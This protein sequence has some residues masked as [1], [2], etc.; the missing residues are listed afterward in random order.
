MRDMYWLQ[1]PGMRKISVRT[2]QQYVSDRRV[3]VWFAFVHSY[4][5]GSSLATRRQSS[6]RRRGRPLAPLSLSPV[7]RDARSSNARGDSSPRCTWSSLRSA[8]A[9]CDIVRSAEACR[10][11]ILSG[12]RS[13]G[14][15]EGR[16]RE[17]HYRGCSIRRRSDHVRASRQRRM[18]SPAPGS[19]RTF[20]VFVSSTF[21]DFIEER[22]ALQRYVFP[23]LAELSRVAR[24][25]SRQSTCAGASAKKPAWTSA[26]SPSAST[27]SPAASG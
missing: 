25:G 16:G 12:R 24:A 10:L 1:A 2:I 22:N 17:Q 3:R 11:P 27:R 19:S 13:V 15:S 4:T 9:F 14:L 6:S 18:T 21:E 23:R 26:P 7:R 5:D 8:G 20:R